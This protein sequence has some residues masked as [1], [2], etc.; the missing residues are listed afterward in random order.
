[1]DLSYAAAV[2]LGIA[3][4]GSALVEIERLTFDDIRSGVGESSPNWG[5]L[6]PRPWPRCLSKRFPSQG[7]CRHPR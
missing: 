7:L 1:M 2:K 3:S 5:R 6:K 4:A